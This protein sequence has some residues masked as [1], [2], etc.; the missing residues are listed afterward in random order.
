VAVESYDLII[1]GGGIGGSALASVMARAG[2]EVLLLER[3]EVFEDHVRGEWMAPWGV[4]EARRVGL[5]DTLLAGGGHFLTHHITY[6]EDIDPAAAEQFVLPLNIFAADVP[7]P[8]TLGHP[9]HCQILIEAAAKAGVTVVRDIDVQTVTPGADPSVTFTADGQ[10]REANARLIV[11]ADGRNSAVRE[12]CGLSLHQDKPHNMIGGMLVDGVE[13]LAEDRQCIGVEGDLHY[14]SFPQ[15]DGRVRIYGC[16]DLEHRAQFAGPEGPRRFLE[17]FQLKSCPQAR[18]IAGGRPAGPL[19]S[20]INSSATLDQPPYAGGA[21]LIG[22]AAGWNDPIIGQG[23]SISY[24]DVRIVSELLLDA[25]DW[26]P[27][28]FAPYAEE[29]AVRM[30]EL[31]YLGMLVA[32]LESEFGETARARRRSYLQRLGA[33]PSLAAHL[34]AVMAGP[35]TAAPEVFTEAQRERVLGPARAPAY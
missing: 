8:L 1:V 18:K 15:G 22:D 4:A 2:R 33:D 13:G 3:T 11:G 10:T 24:R 12:A 5:L 27:T 23:L 29:R 16:Y 19:Y 28:L 34:A 9:R 14:L 6:N 7:G 25:K 20:Y 30:A 32:E 31:R 17:R 35:D 26:S 21:V